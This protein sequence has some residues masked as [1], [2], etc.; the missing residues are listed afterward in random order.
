M[1]SSHKSRTVYF[2][3]MVAAMVGLALPAAALFRQGLAAGPG[4]A[5]LLAWV[6]AFTLALP[7]ALLLLPALGAIASRLGRRPVIPPAGEQIP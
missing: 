6:L 5:L 4:E 7:L 2:L 1:L 3:A